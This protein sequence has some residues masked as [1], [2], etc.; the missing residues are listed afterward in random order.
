MLFWIPGKRNSTRDY[1]SEQERS[2]EYWVDS[3]MGWGTG[4]DPENDPD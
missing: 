3:E 1:A 2:I 4:A